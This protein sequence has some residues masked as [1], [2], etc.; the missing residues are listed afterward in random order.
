M[1]I[2][3]SYTLS[4]ILFIHLPAARMVPDPLY[5]FQIS[6]K[7]RKAVPYTKEVAQHS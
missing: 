6:E 2:L 3:C 7:E 4:K 5:L 1:K